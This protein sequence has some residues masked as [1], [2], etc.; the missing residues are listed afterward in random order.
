MKDIAVSHNVTTA[1]IS[2]RWVL[3]HPVMTLAT[4]TTKKSHMKSDLDVFGFRLTDDEMTS[5]SN[6]QNTTTT[7]ATTNN[8]KIS[9]KLRY[10]LPS[11]D[12]AAVG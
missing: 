2:L 9:H 6:I 1:Q 8:W 12:S 4:G 10:S 3:Q 11:F 5:I 7:T